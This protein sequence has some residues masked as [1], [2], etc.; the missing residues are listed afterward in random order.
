M[1]RKLDIYRYN[2]PLIKTHKTASVGSPDGSGASG[3]G[4]RLNGEQECME[5]VI[6]EEEIER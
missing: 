2:L 4:D 6:H 5:C 1:V 3:M